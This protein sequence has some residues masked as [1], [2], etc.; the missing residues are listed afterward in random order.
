MER[1]S[2]DPAGAGEKFARRGTEVSE[3]RANRFYDRIR[4]SVDRAISGRGGSLNKVKDY[5]LLAPDV[6]ILLWRLARDPRIG[7]R[8]RML[9]G[10]GVAYYLL[11]LDLIP[12]ALIGPVGLLDDLVLGVFILNSVLSDTDEAI[13]R[14]HWSGSEDLLGAIQRVLAAA[15]GLVPTRMV[16]RI[17]KFVR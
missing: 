10:T 12:E 3:R 11:P 4:A 7:G 16:E 17:R 14:E 6:F 1:E 2:F 13:L 8:H 5:L 9:L 15:D